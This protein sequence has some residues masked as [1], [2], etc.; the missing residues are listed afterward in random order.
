MAEPHG[1]PVLRRLASSCSGLV[2]LRRLAPESRRRLSEA[3][4]KTREF[5]NGVGIHAVG[6]MSRGAGRGSIAPAMPDGASRTE[7]PDRA[8]LVLLAL[9]L[10]AAV[11]NLNLAVANVALPSI[12]AGVRLG[13]DGAQ[14][15]R[16][17][18][19]AR[20]R[21]LGALLRRDRRSLRTQADAD[22]RHGAVDSGLPARGV[23]A[24]GRG[25]LRRAPPRWALRRHGLPDHARADH[26]A[27]VRARAAR[28]RSRCGR[29]S[30]ARSPPSARCS[31]ARCS[32]SSGGARSS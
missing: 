14:P 13:A 5:Q 4:S 32:R 22:P 31:P 27:V 19:L 20:P 23:G 2:L 24:D 18:L 3:S 11:A 15:D 21:R 6:V 17:R 12:A 8:G 29:A 10:V 26:G 7:A 9:I 16:G 30:A 1:L 25:A 28:S